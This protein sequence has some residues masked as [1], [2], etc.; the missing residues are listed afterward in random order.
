MGCPGLKKFYIHIVLFF[1]CV[2]LRNW[3]LSSC[4]FGAY[5]LP[6]T[7]LITSDSRSLVTAVNLQ[8]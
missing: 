5:M 7:V 3:C 1:K 4:N 6:V 2:N 8:M